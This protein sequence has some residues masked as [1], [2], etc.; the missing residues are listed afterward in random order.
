MLINNETSASFYL[1]TK[2]I[3]INMRISD[4]N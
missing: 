4:T 2:T 1:V 3:L